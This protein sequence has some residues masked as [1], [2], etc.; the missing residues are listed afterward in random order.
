MPH[1]RILETFNCEC[2]ELIENHLIFIYRENHSSMPSAPGVPS[3]YPH[4]LLNDPI[5]VDSLS[6]WHFH[7]RDCFRLGEFEYCFII[8][9]H[10]CGQNNTEKDLSMFTIEEKMIFEFQINMIVKELIS[11]I[12][13]I[14]P[15][16]RTVNNN[17][18]IAS[19]DVVANVDSG[20][21]NIVLERPKYNGSII[22]KFLAMCHYVT[23]FFSFMKI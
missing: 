7:V 13:S 5:C 10:D 19:G 16:E 15:E 9:I 2:Y 22:T 6:K 3:K 11:N 21:A 4:S 1:L 17:T 14:I 8:P 23:N 12:R 20:G 18:I